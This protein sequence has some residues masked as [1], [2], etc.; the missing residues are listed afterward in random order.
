MD[1]I[2][3]VKE[4]VSKVVEFGEDLIRDDSGADAPADVATEA[5]EPVATAPNASVSDD[6]TD[7]APVAVD[8]PTAVDVAPTQPEVTQ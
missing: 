8:A 5:T 1:I 7:A 6:A 3:E 2:Q 4:V